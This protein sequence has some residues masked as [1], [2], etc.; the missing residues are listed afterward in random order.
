MAKPVGCQALSKHA[1]TNLLPCRVVLCAVWCAAGETRVCIKQQQQRDFICPRKTTRQVALSQAD[2]PR[3]R[4]GRVETLEWAAQA[5]RK[6][7]LAG[8]DFPRGLVKHVFTNADGSSGLRSLVSRETTWAFDDLTT[9]SHARGPVEW[10]HQSLK[11]NVAVAKSPPPTVTTHT[12]HCFAARC[13]FITLERLKMRTTLNH[14]ALKSKLYLTALRSAFATL[15]TLTPVQG[16][17]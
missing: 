5:A 6:I 2:Q 10:Y 4:Y 15:R 12:P 9:T 3:G 11:P 13:G 1:V 16:S 14:F 8:V 17:A 7:S